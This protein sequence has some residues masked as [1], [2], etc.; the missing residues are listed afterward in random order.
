MKQQQLAE[1]QP[2]EELSKYM[3]F[4]PTN[5]QEC[6]FQRLKAMEDLV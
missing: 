3:A 1:E 5:G 4:T 6:D 2:H